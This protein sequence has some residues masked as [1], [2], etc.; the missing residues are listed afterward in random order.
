MDDLEDDLPLSRPLTLQDVRLAVRTAAESYGASQ[1][2]I[3]GRGSLAAS[4][5]DSAEK[6][7]STIDIDL[8]PPWDES[9]AVTWAVADTQI[10]R[11]SAF[12]EKNGFYVE[13]VGEWT[14][15]TQAA[16][17]NERALHLEL[18]GVEVLVLH[19]LDLAYNKLEA[20]RE[21]DIAFMREG[22]NCKAYDYV[23]V[24]EFIQEHA[25][26]SD[27]RQMILENLRQAAS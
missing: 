10:G 24:L 9:K 18:D 14:L 26:D 3:V 25:P 20:G 12:Q 7:R 17:W 8:F 19:P 4:M 5:P 16:G 21:K 1:F 27:T 11:Y 23:E 2:T 15:M 6:L 13:R 22:L